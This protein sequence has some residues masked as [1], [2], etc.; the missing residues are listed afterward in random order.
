MYLPS[1]PAGNAAL[2]V[3]SDLECIVEPGETIE[4][5]AAVPGLLAEKFFERGD[6]VEQGAV[7]ARLESRVERVDIAMAE[8]TSSS[9]TGIELRMLS[10]DY[11]D[12]T[13]RRNITLRESAGV[14]DQQ[15]D[16]VITEAKI[17]ELQMTQEVE[18][19]R[20]AILELERAKALMSQ[21]EIRSPISGLV[22]ERYKSPGEYVDREAVFQ[23]VSLDKLKVEVI[24]P[25]D[26]L[27]TVTPDMN[28]L[29]TIHAP[30]FEN[31]QM[32]AQIDGID[33]VADVASATFGVQLTLPNPTLEIPGGV[34]CQIDFIAT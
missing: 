19:S 28:A 34:R 2:E 12:R 31:R 13:R 33:P 18:S 25:I 5:G 30:G 15:I 21:R 24:V 10:A 22:A 27:G 16:Q 11:G 9:S 20:L 23:L 7:M 6:K 26:Y 1:I 8:E 4:L 32:P 29:I 14:S 17:A 3:L